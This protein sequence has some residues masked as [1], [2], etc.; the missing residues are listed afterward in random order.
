MAQKTFRITYATMSADNEELHAA[1][2]HGVETAKSWLG[3][4]HPFH[5]NGEERWGEGVDEERS[6]IDRDI[7]IGEFAR[8][9]R[10]DARDAVAAAK[11]YVPTWSGMPWQ[12]RIRIMRS[13]A[14]TISERVYEL[15]ALMAIEVGK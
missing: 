15:A 5:V 11:A 4:K 8:A 12:E 1:Y 14:D 3:Q 13:A 9:G 6:P 2:E 7:V 10:Q